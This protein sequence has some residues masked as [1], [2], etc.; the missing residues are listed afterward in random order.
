MNIL[1]RTSDFETWREPYLRII[2]ATPNPEHEQ[3]P[4]ALWKWASVLQ[5]IDALDIEPCNVMDIGAGPSHIACIIAD[6]PSVVKATVIDRDRLCQAVKQHPKIQPI[7]ASFFDWYP[8]LNDKYDLIYDCCALIHFDIG[9]SLAAN[10]GIL[11]AAQ[12]IRELL[13]DDGYFICTSDIL[14]RSTDQNVRGE[15]LSVDALADTFEQGGLHLVSIDMPEADRDLY[16]WNYGH[17]QLGIV[18]LIFRKAWV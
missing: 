5:A 7:L 10:D 16:E 3:K 4:D 12:R 17:M 1:A 18:R 13:T 15:F 2:A 11:K 8:S 6:L 9:T 14:S